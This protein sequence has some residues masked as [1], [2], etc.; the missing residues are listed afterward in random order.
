MSPK[1]KAMTTTMTVT[2][3]TRTNLIITS[4]MWATAKTTKVPLSIYNV[5]SARIQETSDFPLP[6][7]WPKAQGRERT[8]IPVQN[9]SSME[10]QP[11]NL[12]H[13]T[14]ATATPAILPVMSI[15]SRGPAPWTN[16]VLA[17][18]NLF[19]AG[20]WP[21]PPNQDDSPIPATQ[22]KIES[23]PSKT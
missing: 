17:S 9:I 22:K 18:V 11:A 23:D 20:S 4:V 14:T 10:Q 3:S 5:P 8:P 16:T 21:L 13:K 19:I 1:L 7:P 6:K 15:P 12:I 2:Q